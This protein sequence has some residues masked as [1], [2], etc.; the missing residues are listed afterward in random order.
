MASSS[1]EGRPLPSWRNFL[2]ESLMRAVFWPIL[3][4]GLLSIASRADAQQAPT[5]LASAGVYTA[6]QAAKGKDTYAGLCQSCHAP[7]THTGPDFYGK[8]GGKPL[9]ELY[10]YIA[11]LMPQTDPG[12]LTGDEYAQ[13]LAY[14]LKM[15]GMPAGPDALPADSVALKT[16]MFDPGAQ[17]K[18][19]MPDTRSKLRF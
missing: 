4:A 7:A 13:V 16:I 10:V 1:S 8:W 14:L 12:S 19:P 11:T 17:G 18:A 2:K 15:N 9:S 5:R 6:A 3:T